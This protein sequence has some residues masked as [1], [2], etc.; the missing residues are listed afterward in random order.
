MHD[1]VAATP[2]PVRRI[3]PWIALAPLFLLVLYLIGMD[4]GVVSHAG[5]Y[6]HELMHDG[7]H[8][9]ALPCH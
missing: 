5:M 1:I 3:A 8:L 6:L 9:L 4:Q 7:R 2:I